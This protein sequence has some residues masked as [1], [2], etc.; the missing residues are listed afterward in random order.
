MPFIA[1]YRK[2]VTGELDEVQITAI[3]DELERLATLDKRRKTMLDS[4]RE[5]ELLSAALERELLACSTLPELEDRYLPFRVKRR[6]RAQMAREAGLE[7]LAQAIQRGSR[8]HAADYCN[9]HIADADAALAGAR[10]IIAE[11]IADDPEL[12]SALRET[13]QRHARLTSSV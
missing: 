1:R 11:D 4:L 3:R 9:E 7:P 12:R 8:Y 2:E 5:R 10:D 6:T 13:W